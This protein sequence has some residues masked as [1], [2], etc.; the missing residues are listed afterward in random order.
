MRL[1]LLHLAPRVGDLAYNRRL[2]ETA[3]TTAAGLGADWVITPELCLCGYQFASCLG[4]DWIVPQPDPWMRHFCRLVARLRVTA[5][6]SHPERDGHTG[7]LYNTV[8]VIAADGAILGRH[9]KVNVVPGAEAW[10]SRGEQIAPIPVSPFTVGVL[11][12]ADAY[13]PPRTIPA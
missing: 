11:I 10:A 7:K 1:A 9:R 2:V 8:F 3:V 13:P 5:F 6:L 12:C 4:T